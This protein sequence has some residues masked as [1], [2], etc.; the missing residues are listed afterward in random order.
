MCK[1]VVNTLGI[2]LGCDRDYVKRLKTLMNS[3]AGV[4]LEILEYCYRRDDNSGTGKWGMI[5]DALRELG[6]ETTIEKLGLN[7]RASMN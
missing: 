7:S 6:K 4:T 5:I 3:V 1:G 2:W